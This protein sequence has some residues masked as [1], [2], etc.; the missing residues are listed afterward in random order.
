MMD[1]KKWQSSDFRE[2]ER[3]ELYAKNSAPKRQRWLQKLLGSLLVFWLISKA[4][5]PWTGL[6]EWEQAFPE[7]GKKIAD[8]KRQNT[9][10]W[11]V[12]SSTI[13]HHIIP[14]ELDSITA[15]HGL[16]WYN[17]GLQRC[18]P[19]ES[20]YLTH[21]LLDEK[22]ADDLDVLVFEVQP[23]EI[24]SW[25]EI[26]SLRN[27]AQLS[28]FETQRRIRRIPWK[29]PNQLG[30]NW[31][32]SRILIWGWLQHLIAFLRPAQYLSRS[33]VTADN[34]ETKGFVELKA[35]DSKTGRLAKTHLQW[36]RSSD[37]LIQHQ[38]FIAQDF[39]Y[40]MTL[41]DPT[42][43]WDCEG[44]VNP[45]LDQMEILLNKCESKGIHCLFHFQN[46]WDTNGC[47]YFAALEKWG[48]SHVFESMGYA[49]NEDLFEA[50]DRYDESHLMRS[51]AKKFTSSFGEK[52]NLLFNETETN[53]E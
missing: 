31:E 41:A 23:E 20:F 29:A 30:A 16:K 33:E 46:L 50:T 45:I 13:M 32:Q 15:N 40:R 28:F 10:A 52:L 6:H 4:I 26:S 53:K 49:G 35:S 39:D 1:K 47:I 22:D 21:V 24:L 27:T 19:P 25:D 51:G 12:G 43:N 14:N 48:A 42:I 7:F 17:F 36:T 2:V 44:R 11:I 38:I 8:V 37:S 3:S 18:A 9:N 5:T 34:G